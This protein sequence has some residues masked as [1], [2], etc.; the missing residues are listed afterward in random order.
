VTVLRQHPTSLQLPVNE[1]DFRYD[2]NCDNRILAND[3]T[4][5]RQNTTS[6]DMSACTNP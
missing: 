4:V 5:L 2:L 3:Q 1:T 6:L